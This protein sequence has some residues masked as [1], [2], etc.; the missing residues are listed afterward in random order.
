MKGMVEMPLPHTAARMR[1]GRPEAR[2]GP[3]P[4]AAPTAPRCPKPPTPERQAAARRE[5]NRMQHTQV[6]RYTC[7]TGT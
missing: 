4:D 2:S 1:G 5:R 6:R 3:T 7:A